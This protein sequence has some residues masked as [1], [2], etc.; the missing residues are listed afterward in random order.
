RLRLF[1]GPRRLASHRGAA[2]VDSQRVAGHER[3][4]PAGSMNVRCGPPR[5]PPSFA[6]RHQPH[7]L[8]EVVESF[9]RN[10]DV[11]IGTGMN[12][13]DAAEALEQDFLFHHSVAIDLYPSQ[14][15]GGQRAEQHVMTPTRKLAASVE[16]D[17]S[18]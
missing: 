5:D 16:R 10:V 3:S 9:D 15:L 7:Q 2:D 18:G 6:G 13:A 11:A 1:I 8:S 12:V 4:T 14:F 17:W